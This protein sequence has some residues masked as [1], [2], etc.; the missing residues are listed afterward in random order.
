MTDCVEKR[1]VRISVRTLVE[2]MGRSGDLQ[3]GSGGWRDKEAMQKGS[4]IHRKIQ[5]RMGPGYQ[6]EVP[7]KYEAEREHCMLVLEGR[8]DGILEDADGVLIDEIKGVYLDVSELE[9]PVQVHL[10]QAKCYAA[11]YCRQH[12][13]ENIRVQL[14][15]CQMETEEIRRFV[16]NFTA[17]ELELWF[18]DLLDGYGVWA[19]LQVLSRQER[20]ASMQELAFPF[21]Y[22]EGQ[23]QLVADI[24]RTVLR[25]KQLFVQAPTGVGKT[26]SAVYPAVRALGEELAERIFYLTAK[27]ITRTV[28]EEAFSIL[29]SHG[30]KCRN[31]TIT[32]KEKLCVCEEPD[33]DPELCP[34]AKGHYDRVNAALYNM[35]TEQVQYDRES[36]LL[37]SEA[38]TVCPYELQLDL[39]MFADAIICD[40]N[41]AFDPTVRLKRFFGEG[42]AQGEGLFLIDEAHNL[43]E[44]GREMY[45]A[46]IVKEEVLDVKRKIKGQFPKVEKALERVNRVLLELKRQCDGT[47][48]LEQAGGLI[49]ALMN[50]AGQ[51]DEMLGELKGGGLR[52]ELLEFYFRV[53]EFLGIA[54]LLDENYMIYGGYLSDGSFMVRLFC[55]NPAVNLQK[56]LDRGRSTVFFSATMLPV[57]YYQKMLSAREDDYAVYI[58]SPF[59]AENR[60]IAIGADVSSRY[61]RRTPEEFRRVASYIEKMVRAR[62]GN[63]LVFFPSYSMLESVAEYIEDLLL[64]QEQPWEGELFRQQPG[65]NEAER[66]AFLQAFSA[67][68]ERPCL[69]LCVMGGIFGEGIDLT[70]EALIGA[71]VVGPGIPQVGEERELLKRYYDRKGE[72]GFDIAYR[73]PGMNKVL[74]AAGRVIRTSEDRGVILLLDDRFRN[75]ETRALFPAE[76][77]DC[78]VTALPHI[79][80]G[81]REFWEN[82]KDPE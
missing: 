4:R 33:C 54:D 11:I 51:M 43:V 35:L 57:R 16:K 23:K 32:A 36:I 60:M 30:L 44:R 34:R 12:S 68:R 45:S 41:Y 47:T 64:N 38:F 56:C 14:T 25:K 6:A 1:R 28:A 29:K 18:S 66:E 74:Q 65:L 42:A 3:G 7:L 39:A 78:Q 75:S 73:F 8:A 59:P 58:P 72:N 53:Y 40:Y 37:Q 15:Y 24:Y 13:L 27:T 2:F 61:T 9:E 79:D 31:I 62:E 49:L 48:E 19:D 46:S 80:A 26:M 71:A 17:E 76:W 69:G 20:N 10:S 55:V 67:D 70:G 77:R 82:Q 5:K 22:R 52:N 21:E 81:L 63:Y 50:L